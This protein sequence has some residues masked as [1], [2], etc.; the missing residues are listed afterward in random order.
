MATYYWKGNTQ[1]GTTG[2]GQLTGLHRDNPEGGFNQHWNIPGNWLVRVP[3]S[4]FGSSGGSSGD[5]HLAPTTYVPG[6]GDV[7]VFTRLS[8][9]AFGLTEDIPLSNCTVGGHYGTSGWANAASGKTSGRLHMLKVEANWGHNEGPANFGHELF[10]IVGSKIGSN[11]YDQLEAMAMDTNYYGTSGGVSFGTLAAGQGQDVDGLRIYASKI[12]NISFKPDSMR[13]VNSSDVFNL[14]LRGRGHRF[15]TQ[16]TTFG[17]V[18]IDNQTVNVSTAFVRLGL[19]G[20]RGVTLTGDVLVGNMFSRSNAGDAYN[21]GQSAFY[22][23]A[24]GT[25]NRI[26]I[27]VPRRPEI[28]TIA[29]NVGTLNVY[30]ESIQ[31]FEGKFNG[32]LLTHG[33]DGGT[34]SINTLNMKQNAPSFNGVSREIIS[35]DDYGT[36]YYQDSVVG[37]NNIVGIDEMSLI[38]S[39]PDE[40]F[41]NLEVTNLNLEG[42]RFVI[43]KVSNYGFTGAGAQGDRFATISDASNGEIVIKG[44]FIA[45]DCVIDLIHPSES[46][47]K[48][49]KI[50]AGITHPVNGAGI[51]SLG[52]NGLILTPSGMRIVADYET[53]DDGATLGLISSSVTKRK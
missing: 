17:D 28:M 10:N 43:G 46:G 13:L 14:T 53:A 34:L 9:G 44:G 20:S 8:A 50:G 33:A 16:D 45:N 38:S 51:Q 24:H 23:N 1:Y 3:G 4:T 22:L 27:D 40:A 12:D 39:V 2:P 52:T 19:D 37:M 18:I 21:L 48:G 35:R 15:E 41:A 29:A 26:D 25:V 47:F 49:V 5:F 11:P 6:G 30:P 7:A 32:V 36:V 31:N 42:G